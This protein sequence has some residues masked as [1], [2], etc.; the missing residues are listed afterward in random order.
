M[1]VYFFKKKNLFWAL[2][3]LTKQIFCFLKK[4][5]ILGSKKNAAFVRQLDC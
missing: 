1:Q 5:E 2:A 4:N 3:L